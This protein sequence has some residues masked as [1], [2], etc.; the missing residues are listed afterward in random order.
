MIE[1]FTF[2]Q[3]F[4]SGFFRSRPFRA[5]IMGVDAFRTDS[6]CSVPANFCAWKECSDVGQVFPFSWTG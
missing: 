1:S 4:R 3:S 5:A 2:S 6:S